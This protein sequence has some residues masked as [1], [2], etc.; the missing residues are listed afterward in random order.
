MSLTAPTGTQQKEAQIV[1]KI[2]DLILRIE[3]L[4]LR[5]ED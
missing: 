1:F 5:I 4:I 2:E 3:D